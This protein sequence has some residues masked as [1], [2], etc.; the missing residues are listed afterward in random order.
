MREDIKKKVV[1]CE[2][3]WMK[4][5][6]GVTEE[7]QPMNGGKYVEENGEGGEVFNF[8]QFN[9]KCYGYVMH[10]GDELH[11]E[12]YDKTLKN[13]S[14][15]ADMTVVWVASD[16][17]GC[18]IVGWYEHAA[19]YREWQQ[20]LAT[21][22]KYYDYNFTAEDKNCFLIPEKDRKFVVP[23]APQAGKGKGM[24]Q[25]QVW[26]AD[27]EYAQEELI[28]K[29]LEYLNSVKECCETPYV[30]LEEFEKRVEDGGQPTEKLMEESKKAWEER[31]DFK[32]FQYINLAID[33]DECLETRRAKAELF[34][35]LEYLDE[36]EEEYKR[37]LYCKQDMDT[38]VDFMVLEAVLGHIFLVI[39]LGEK[40]R[41]RKG[42]C[43]N[44]TGVARALAYTYIDE[45][46]W[47]KAEELMAECEK[48][49]F[50]HDWLD[51][52]REYMKELREEK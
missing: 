18:K 4:H 45:E 43:G 20:Y 16:G 2:V 12:R 44:W 23:R 47:G 46:E 51:D 52:A 13:H 19:M 31:H 49:T 10:Y 35:D 48:E 30:P 34:R 38:M 6:R 24:G 5:Y 33:K 27:S 25:S 1:F 41:G 11:I 3:A 26:Y 50:A 17:R 42:E 7:D 36:A 14:E 39:E 9:R 8:K 32:A 22:F 29:V 15:A 21:D 40:I 28:P 37:A